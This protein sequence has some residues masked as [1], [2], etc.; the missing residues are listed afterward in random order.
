MP[1]MQPLSGPQGL[2]SLT[3]AIQNK[4]NLNDPS[5][6]DGCNSLNITSPTIGFHGIGPLGQI[7]PKVQP[8]K[9]SS[10]A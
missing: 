6:Y 10:K 3:Y 9:I 5:Q 4:I 2:A 7:I 8:S 1:G